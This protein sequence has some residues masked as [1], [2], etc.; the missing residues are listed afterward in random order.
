MAG[1]AFVLYR[2]NQET[3][4]DLKFLFNIRFTIFSNLQQEYLTIFFFTCSRTISHS[5]E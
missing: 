5:I 3:F 4:P 1:D 2:L